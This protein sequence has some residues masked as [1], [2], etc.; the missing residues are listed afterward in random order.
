MLHNNYHKMFMHASCYMG[1]VTLIFDDINIFITVSLVVCDLVYEEVKGQLSNLWESYE[2]ERIW[3]QEIKFTM[4]KQKVST[5]KKYTVSLTSFSAQTDVR[6]FLFL[7]NNIN[8]YYL[9][10]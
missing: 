10:N 5:D 4:D 8:I 1:R 6:Q 7:V 3:S 2:S 9:H